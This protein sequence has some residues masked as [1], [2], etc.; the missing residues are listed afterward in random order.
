MAHL[1][2]VGRARA[3]TRHVLPN[4]TSQV[5]VAATTMVGWAILIAASLNFLGF[6]VHPPSADWGVDLSNGIRYA[7]ASWWYATF[8]GVAIAATILAV[9]RIGDRIA[10]RLD[11]RQ[12]ERARLAPL[13]TAP[14]VGAPGLEEAPR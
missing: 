12:A 5:L 6:G 2:G 14:V 13:E 3:L 9:N 1:I 8:P 10:A 7:N 11:P 4:L